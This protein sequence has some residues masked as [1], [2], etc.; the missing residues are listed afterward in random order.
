MLERD[1]VALMVYPLSLQYVSGAETDY[2]E[3]LSGAQSVIRN[4]TARTTCGF[5]SSFAL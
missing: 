1:G 2:R 3:S 4:P 5:R